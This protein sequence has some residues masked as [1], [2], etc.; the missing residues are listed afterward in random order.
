MYE[1]FTDHAHKVMALANQEAHR[2]N[3]EYIGTEHILLGLAMEGTGVAAS[4]LKDLHTDLVKLRCE[5]DKLVKHGPGSGIVSKLP[6]TP[7]GKKVVEYAIAEA[8]RFDH[9]YVGTEHLLLGLLREQDGMAAQ[10]L[11]NLGLTLDRVRQDV[12]NLLEPTLDTKVRGEKPDELIEDAIKSL[13]VAGEMAGTEGNAA[14]AS[15]L[16]GEVKHLRALLAGPEDG[17]GK[18]ES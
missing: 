6:L 8:R 3:H 2:L 14:L 9:T 4:V 15:A 12:L 5:V 13:Q 1:R 10:I 17:S 18:S 11:G 7:H 16:L